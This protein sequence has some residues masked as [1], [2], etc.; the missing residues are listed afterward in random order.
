MPDLYKFGVMIQNVP[1]KCMAVKVS[2]STI[3][4]GRKAPS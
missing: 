3:P 1:L 4:D 2:I